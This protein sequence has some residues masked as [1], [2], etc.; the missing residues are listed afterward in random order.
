MSFLFAVLSKWVKAMLATLRRPTMAGLLIVAA[1]DTAIAQSVVSD[2]NGDGIDDLAVGA[3]L[4]GGRGSVS[5]FFGV[6][7]V[8]FGTTVKTPDLVRYG[9]STGEAYGFALTAADFNRDGR[10]ELVVGAPLWNGSRGRIEI[11]RFV[12]SGGFLFASPTSYS[13]DSADVL[14]IAEPGDWFG[15]ALATGDFDGNSYPDLA[16]GIPGE[17]LLGLSNTGAVQI[18]RATSAGIT[19]AG[20]RFWS[21]RTT[22]IADDIEPEDWFG[23]ALAGGDF[24]GDGIDD[25]AVGVPFEDLTFLNQGAVNVI[26]GTSTGLSSQNNRF[27]SIAQGG[28]FSG[29]KLGQALAA[30]DINGDTFA[31]LAIG[32]PGGLS[33]A[34][35]VAVAYGASSGLGGLSVNWQTLDPPEAG[36]ALGSALTVADFNGD[37][38]ADVAAGAPGEDI[39]GLADAGAVTVFYGQSSPSLATEQFWH[40]NSYGVQD[41]IEM[42]DFFGSGLAAGDYN[43]DGL[44]DLAIGVAQEDVGSIVNVGLINVITGAPFGLY[45]GPDCLLLPATTYSGGLFGLALA[46]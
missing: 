31:D 24:N 3:P 11:L 30:G 9:T 6:P 22:G 2:F 5:V 43:G 15:R 35:F 41:K 4:A 38:F 16:I 46:K 25:L 18:F 21:Q 12:S 42:S 7:G 37:G 8:G 1:A 39:S 23:A 26:Y 13:Q 45:S 19:V 36:D 17:D 29:A 44:A 27:L 10:F 33:G 34:G 32:G 14:D 40:Q 20:N 28:E